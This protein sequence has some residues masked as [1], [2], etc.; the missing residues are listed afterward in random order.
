MAAML[1]TAGL[2]T[3][4]VWRRRRDMLLEHRFAAERAQRSAVER[5]G[6]VMRY[7]NDSIILFDAEMRIVDANERATTVYGHSFYELRRLTAVDLRGPDSRTRVD[8][9]FA[10]AMRPEGLVF[11]TVHR[12]KDGTL[13]PVEVG[14]RPVEVDGRR[15]VLS[16]VRDITERKAR[17]Q[18]IERLSRMYRVLCQANEAIVRST[19]TSELLSS[20]CQILVDSGRFEMAWVGW[21]NP[22][23]RAIEP[24][25]KFNDRLG[26]VDL[27]KI[28]TDDRPEGR[29]PTGR[30][31]RENQTCVFND[32]LDNPAAGLWRER[33]FASGIYAAIALPLRRAGAVVGVLTVYASQK[34]WFGP[35]EIALLEQ[36]ASDLSFGLDVLARDKQ[37]Q[38]AEEALRIGEERFRAIF[39]NADV[40]MAEIALSGHL[41]R[42]NRRMAQMLG[43]PAT[44]L[45]GVY[46]DSVVHENFREETAQLIQNLC[47]GT[48]PACTYRRGPRC[49]REDGSAFWSNLT[50]TLQT[51][52]SGR[53][54]G[55]ICLLQDI[56]Q[57]V[58]AR[59]TL[60]RF[61]T[62]LEKKVAFRTEELEDRTRQV[63][64]FL[65]SIPDMV[66]RLRSDGTVLYCQPAQGGGI[67]ELACLCGEPGE[68]CMN[69]ALREPV[70]SVGRRALREKNLIVS[71][72]RIGAENQ[73]FEL[74][75][76]AAP[77]GS[78][79]FVVFVRDIT[80]RKRLESE[81]A[82]ALQREREVSQ[83]KSRFISFTS[84][85]FRTPMAAAVGS[86][87]LLENHFDHL[88]PAKRQA[89]LT[90]I[91]SSLRRMS[92]M[93]DEILVLNRMDTGRVKIQAIELNLERFVGDAIEEVRLG[94]QNTHYFEFQAVGDATRVKTDPNVLHHV[95]TNLLSN[96]VRYSPSGTRVT[97]S[98]E[99]SATEF[100][101]AVQDQG[102]GV[103]EA[104]RERIFEPFERGSNIGEI[105]GNGLG[106][107]IVKRMTALLGGDL[108][109]V[110]GQGSGSK[111][112]ARFPQPSPA[113]MPE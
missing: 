86:A 14:S 21:P 103:P 87:E 23:S 57:E 70:L 85:E 33:A 3:S 69:A 111:F 10:D 37:H 30:A 7:A 46:I 83:M 50:V 89:L 24:V 39:E 97:L 49:I 53:P 61:N 2:V 109:L 91:N 94:D 93:L 26:Y 41:T 48:L 11:E 22:P 74:E 19:G 100:C 80:A 113:P 36:A 84:H 20:I 78:S 38:M 75:M 5:L 96:A 54:V 106:L 15:H 98:V 68:N 31:Y 67:A 72:S 6:I 9:D 59:E 63:Q 105:R 52:G 45:V 77:V 28:S 1:I 99:A 104:D 110:S 35:A 18:Q 73:V 51:D 108:T 102:I 71:E 60:Q 32:M 44:E 107:N 66:M 76:R 4:I 90:R 25:A 112:T 40:G 65:K 92:E 16:I 55:C 62:E 58:A 42:V 47:S 64:A 88:T 34:D 95:L 29:G 12:R 79:E 82:A 13:F 43:R 81:I 17:E 8:A 27:L 56:S 101:I